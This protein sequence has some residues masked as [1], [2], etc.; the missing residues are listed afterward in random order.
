MLVMDGLNDDR[1]VG[2]DKDRGEFHP[3]ISGEGR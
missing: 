1:T 2:P 3:D